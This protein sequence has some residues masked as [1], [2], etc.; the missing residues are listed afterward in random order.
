MGA[1]P[2]IFPLFPK[3]VSTTSLKM[4]GLHSIIMKKSHKST[5]NTDNYYKF[6][7]L[8]KQNFSVLAKNK[9]WCMDFTYIKLINGKT[10]YNC[11]IINLF[12]KSIIATANSKNIDGTLAINTLSTAILSEAPQDGMIVHTG[13]GSQFTSQAFVNFCISQKIT[14]SMSRLGCSYDSAV[15]ERFFN[16]LKL[17]FINI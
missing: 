15:I 3:I 11:S 8:V 17:S 10:I 12:D 5:K 1:T 2:I 14:Q 13:H 9:I 4:L 7:N 16:T 6:P